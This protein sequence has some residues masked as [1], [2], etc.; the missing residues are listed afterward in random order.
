MINILFVDDDSDILASFR[1]MLRP[2]R[3]EWRVHFTQS[4]EAGLEMIKKEPFDVVIADMRMPG[5]GGADLLLEVERLQP[6]TIR[7]ILSG[8]SEMEALLKSVR[9]AH[10]F[11]S[12]PCSS[13]VLM[14]T[15]E[16]VI[17]LRHILANEQVRKVVGGLESLPALPELY[18]QIEQELRS[19]EPSLK[20]VGELVKQDMGVSASLLKV[21]NS[22]FF[23]FFKKI[24]S[25]SHAVT[26][27]GIEVLKGLVLGVKLIKSFDVSQFKGYSIER[28]WN[29][30]LGVAAFAK[31]IARE[32]GLSDSMCDSLFIAG[33]LHDIG[34]LVLAT[35]MYDEYKTVLELVCQEGGTILD[36]ES[37]ILNVTHAEVGAYLLGVWRMDMTVTE[38]VFGHHEPQRSWDGLSPALIVHVANSFQHELVVFNP[39]R[40]FVQL[41]DTWIE[42]QG[43]AE[44]IQVW[45]DACKELLEREQADDA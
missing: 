29:H 13:D 44:R 1:A 8:Y 35:Q 4:A 24:T 25:P 34:K 37:R 12:K 22:S 21:V 11:L 14:S 39:L 27:L 40:E 16:R 7:I 15:I 31:V 38:A 32:E 5:M 3:K 26:L 6:S 45:R 18:L 2:K 41:N 19:D 28:L 42:E 33:L 17:S 23:G 43:V 20:R 36:A 30:C 10:Q 9:P